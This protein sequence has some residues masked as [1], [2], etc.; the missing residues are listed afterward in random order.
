MIQF[1]WFN[2]Y[3]KDQI[4]KKRQQCFPFGLGG[5]IHWIWNFSYLKFSLLANHCGRPIFLTSTLINLPRPFEPSYGSDNVSFQCKLLESQKHALFPKLKHC[6]KN[7]VF[8][9]GF[10]QETAGLVIFTEEILN[11]KL[12]SMCSDVCCKDFHKCSFYFIFASLSWKSLLW[13]LLCHW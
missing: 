9:Y 8:H 11:R 2:W 12:H 4:W 5:F 6:T 13:V 7:E 1:F 10:L 3:K